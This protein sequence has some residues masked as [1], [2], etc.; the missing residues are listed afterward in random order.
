M[1][2][3]HILIIKDTADQI[4]P[5]LRTLGQKLAILVTGT[6]PEQ[7]ITKRASTMFMFTPVT[8]EQVFNVI[9]KLS[10][11]KSCGLDKSF[12]SLP[13]YIFQKLYTISSTKV[14]IREFFLTV[15]KRAKF[16]LCT[17]RTV[18]TRLTTIDQYQYCR[19]SPRELRE[20][21]ILKSL[22]SSLN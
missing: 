17:K 2:I 22:N 18:E 10:T 13:R 4:N 1:G 6:P 3:K 20:Q 5:H 14:L 9:S 16:L 15:G 11:S 8:N 12:L 21:C 7:F 19:P